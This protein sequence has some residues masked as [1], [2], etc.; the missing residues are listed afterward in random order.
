MGPE[1][2]ATFGTA[3]QAPAPTPIAAAPGVTNWISP[4]WSA[5]NAR[6]PVVCTVEG[7]AFTS[8]RLLTAPTRRVPAALNT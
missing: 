2:P 7:V 4:V 3:A 5:Q 8:N 6:T 1:V